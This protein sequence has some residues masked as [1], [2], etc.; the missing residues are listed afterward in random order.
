MKPEEVNTKTV[1]QEQIQAYLNT[2]QAIAVHLLSQ[3]YTRM[4]DKYEDLASHPDKTVRDTAETYFLEP[5][6]DAV[7]AAERVLEANGNVPIHFL[8]PSMADA[9]DTGEEAEHPLR[10]VRDSEE[11][12]DDD[13]G[14]DE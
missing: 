7:W 12:E 1:T 5:I 10:V 14:E 8:S 4:M 11:D 3:D 6:L 9:E 2:R 13:E